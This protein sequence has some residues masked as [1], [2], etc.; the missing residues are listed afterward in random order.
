M[1]LTKKFGSQPFSSLFGNCHLFLLL[2]E[3]IG[4]TFIRHDY[5]LLIHMPKHP[6]HL[7]ST[8]LIRLTKVICT[9]SLAIGFCRIRNTFTSRSSIARVVQSII[10]QKS[11]WTWFRCMWIVNS[12]AY[13]TFQCRTADMCTQLLKQTI[14]ALLFST[15]D[16]LLV[17]KLVNYSSLLSS[18]IL[19]VAYTIENLNCIYPL[20]LIILVFHH[21]CLTVEGTS[22]VWIYICRYGELV[23]IIISFQ[24]NKTLHSFTCYKME[25]CY[26]HF[27][28]AEWVQNYTQHTHTHSHL[29]SITKSLSNEKSPAS[30]SVV[31]DKDLQS[32]IWTLGTY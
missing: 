2:R 1:N 30:C 4:S 11:L 5:P 9:L 14:I 20:N 7:H 28:R 15:I 13:P 6:L 18:M 16:V 12:N 29:Q 26:I 25:F 31:I 3:T 24:V 22:S 23:F 27:I 10:K 32:D 19:L 17:L 8:P 21:S